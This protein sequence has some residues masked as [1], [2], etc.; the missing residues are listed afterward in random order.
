LAI[1]SITEKS[2]RRRIEIILHIT[3]KF[4]FDHAEE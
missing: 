1:L 4:Q 2:N 3:L